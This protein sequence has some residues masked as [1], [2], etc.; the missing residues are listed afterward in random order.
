LLK[1]YKIEEP[2]ERSSSIIELQQLE[3]TKESIEESKLIEDEPGQYTPVDCP[4]NLDLARKDKFMIDLRNRLRVFLST[5]L[6]YEP[7]SILQFI[8]PISF[9]LNK[10]HAIIKM[11]LGRFKECFQICI[12]E[13]GHDLSFAQSVAKK[14]FEWHD[15]DRRIYYNLF[16]ILVSSNDAEHK[17]L[18]I[19]VLTK[20]CQYIPYEKIT[21]NFGED[22]EFTEDLNNLFSNVFKQMD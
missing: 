7:F 1:K 9:Y 6:Q 10:E 8:E 11:K 12:N 13:I 17:K 15:K 19:Q 2:L 3:E 21:K 4:Y 16:R 5:S 18:A 20:N 14:G 22:D